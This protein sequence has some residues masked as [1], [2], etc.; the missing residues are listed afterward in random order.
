LLKTID[1]TRLEVSATLNKERRSELGQFMTPSSIA[2]FM[3]SLFA[4]DSD[5]PCRVIDPGAGVGSLSCAFIEHFRKTTATAKNFELKAFEIDPILGVQLEEMLACYSTTF[6]VDVQILHQD[7]VEWATEQIYKHRINDFTHAI[8]NPPYKKISRTS[9]H[10]LMLREVNIETVNLY[11]AFVALSLK[12]LADKGQLVAIIPRSFCNGPYYK[13]FRKILLSHAAIRHIHLFESRNK[14]FKDDQVLQENIIVL[15]ERGGLQSTVTIST[16]T[17]DS[18]SDYNSDEHD[19]NQIVSPKDKEYF[20]HIPTSKESGSIE[21]SLDYQSSLSDLFIEV[22]TGPVVDF[23]VRESIREGPEVGT[24]PLLYP[25]HF[26][27]NIINWPKYDWKKSNSILRDTNTEK[28]LYPSGF[29]TVVRRFSSKE[30]SR[31]IHA[32]VVNPSTLPDYEAFGFENHLNVFHFKKRGLSENMTYGLAAY[33][34]STV[35]DNY[36]RRFN[37][38]TQ[39]NATDLRTLKYPNQRVL[40]SLGE[41][42]K[43]F[44]EVTQSMIDDKLSQLSI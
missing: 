18:F 30:E 38:H 11:S 31:R 7:F 4:I 5:E 43:E 14:A 15:L 6:N 32:S 20:V 17:D 10:R 9:S 8:L 33:L 44:R 24:V 3:A 27:G 22:S 25:G 39:V 2:N 41:W 36:F 16:S 35:V 34:N 28:L 37:G 26:F 23:R 19:F 29:Y 42:S 21:F 1:K 13:D 12:L 40:D